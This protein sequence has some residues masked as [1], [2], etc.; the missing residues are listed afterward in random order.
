VVLLECYDYAFTYK[1]IDG[2]VPM[3]VGD[4]LPEKQ[5]TMTATQKFSY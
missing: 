2:A 5:R 4:N 1:R 3:F